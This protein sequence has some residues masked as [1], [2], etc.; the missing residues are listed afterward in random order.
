MV[1]LG[2][3]GVPGSGKTTLSRAIASQ[4]RDIKEFSHVELVNEYARR[5]ISKHG[6]VTSIFEQYRILEKQLEWEDSV[7]NEHLDLMITDSPVFLGFIYCCNLPKT[8]SKEIMFF[9]DVFKKMVKVNY[10]KPRYDILLHLGTSRKPLDDGIRIPEQ[11]KDSW[12]SQAD[13]MI[14]ATMSVFKPKIFIEVPEGELD[15]TSLWCIDQIRR[16][17]YGRVQE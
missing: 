3:T 13:T 12:R 8:N 1:R 15:K 2:I 6:P 17:I 9:N 4:C 14:R 16:E 11:F 5:Y 7:C 10:P